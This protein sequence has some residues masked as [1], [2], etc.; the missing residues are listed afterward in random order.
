MTNAKW[1]EENRDAETRMRVVY[2]ELWDQQMDIFKEAWRLY[3]ATDEKDVRLRTYQLNQVQQSADRL[4]VLLTRI[5]PS[6]DDIESQKLL[7]ELEQRVSLVEG[8]K[9][10]A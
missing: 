1:Y 7:K 6:L 2:K 9:K 8:A 5:T 10:R 3:E 4:R